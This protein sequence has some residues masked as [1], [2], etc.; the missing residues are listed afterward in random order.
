MTFAKS[1]GVSTGIGS[2]EG[3]GRGG[4]C[5]RDFSLWLGFS[6]HKLRKSYGWATGSGAVSTRFFPF[7]LAS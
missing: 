5:G 7:R 6:N 1:D 4:G 2:P 3:R